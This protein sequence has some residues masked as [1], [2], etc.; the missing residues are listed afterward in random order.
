MI[1][2]IIL[3][4]AQGVAEWLPISSEGLL[5][6]LKVNVFKSSL[7]LN[8]LISYA[9]FLHLGTF[10]AALV[11]FRKEVL[12]LLKSL[13]SNKRKEA[14]RF[15]I[16]S[17]VITG[18]VGILIL[19]LLGSFELSSAKWIMLLIGIALLVTAFLQFIKKGEQYK[20]EKDLKTIDSVIL[21]ILQGF[22]IIPGLSRSGLTVSGLLLRK[23]SDTTALKLSFIMS[24]PAVLAGNILLN[25]DKLALS[26]ENLLGLLFSFLFG[27][28]TIHIL[29][30]LS[31]KINFAWFVLLFGLIVIASVFLISAPEEESTKPS[32]QEIIG[33]ETVI[34]DELKMDIDEDGEEEDIVLYAKEFFHLA[35]IDQ[36]EMKSSIE[37]LAED[38]QNI[39]AKDFNGDGEELEF[40]FET[41]KSDKGVYVEIIGWDKDEEELV[42]YS[43]YKDEDILGELLASSMDDM[44]WRHGFL[45]QSYDSLTNY[46]TFSKEKQGFEFKKSD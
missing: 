16:I 46:Y 2:S 38:V 21:G 34:K 24:L 15:Y 8:S 39:K 32:M 29:L 12:D 23:F 22:S 27:I 37:L 11:Y 31:Q 6:L 30:K 14:V 4:F 18:I 19:K 1:E 42:R 26:P 35:V 28:L 45:M 33:N 20:E 44:G 36:S 41:Y 5:V 25:L 7:S 3:G 13:F 9:L 17:T 10:L 43:F 40:A